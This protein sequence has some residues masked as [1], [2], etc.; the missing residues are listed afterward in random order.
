MALSRDGGVPPMTSLL[1][2]RFVGGA[3]PRL[4]PEAMYWARWIRAWYTFSLPLEIRLVNVPAIVDYDGVE[5]A[6]RWWQSTRGREPFIAEL[7]VGA[8]ASTLETEGPTTAYP[9]VFA[10]IGRILKYYFQAESNSWYREDYAERWGDKLLDAYMH[11]STPPPPR[12]G[13]KLR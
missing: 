3:D 8:F 13:M 11:D 6:M 1:R 10:A 7:A 2:M 9:T 12:S 4:R 5:C